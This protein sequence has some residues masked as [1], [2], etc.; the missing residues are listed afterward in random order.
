VE[1]NFKHFVKLIGA[2]IKQSSIYKTL[3]I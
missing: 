1:N 3:N 2:K